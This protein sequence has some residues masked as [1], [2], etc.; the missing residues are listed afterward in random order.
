MT[1]L[2]Q[3]SKGVGGSD[4]TT[5]LQLIH[6]NELQKKNGRSLRKTS[7]HR[8]DLFPPNY[9]KITGEKECHIE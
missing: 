3:Y 8:Q 7:K 1:L 9:S 5:G 2:N 6:I 4:M